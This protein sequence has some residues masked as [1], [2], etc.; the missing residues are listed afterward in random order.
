MRLWSEGRLKLE[1]WLPP[2]IARDERPPVAAHG[3]R[4]G[5]ERGRRRSPRRSSDGTRLETDHVLLATG[6]RV[7]H[8]ARALPRRS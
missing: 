3:D 1:P 4:R 8:A 2:R 6:Y 5:I 7:G